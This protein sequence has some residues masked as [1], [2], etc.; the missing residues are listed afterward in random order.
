[1]PLLRNIMVIGIAVGVTLSLTPSSSANSDMIPEAVVRCATASPENPELY[2]IVPNKLKFRARVVY[3]G[4]VVFLVD[5]FLQEGSNT[6]PL[7]GAEKS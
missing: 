6:V 5:A 2:V 1:M 3:E 4:R 7:S